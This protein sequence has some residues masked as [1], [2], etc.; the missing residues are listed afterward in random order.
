MISIVYIYMDDKL[1]LQKVMRQNRSQKISYRDELILKKAIQGFSFQEISDNFN[2]LH[3]LQF[4]PPKKG[5]PYL[6]DECETGEMLN[7]GD[8]DYC[9]NCGDI[10]YKF[11]A[12]LIEEIWKYTKSTHN[13]GRWFTKKL[14]TLIP[15]N[16]DANFLIDDFTEVYRVIVEHKLIRTVCWQIFLAK[17]LIGNIQENHTHES[18]SH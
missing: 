12:P 2:N 7:C 4:L 11:V 1:I 18:I 5:N 8:F 14:E 3:N 15:H 16:R 13:H 17:L 10:E 9:T 6:C